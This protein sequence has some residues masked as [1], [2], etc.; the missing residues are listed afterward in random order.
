MGIAKPFKFETIRIISKCS[1][2]KPGSASI[3][4]YLIKM[5]TNLIYNSIV[6]YKSIY[7]KEV[8]VKRQLCMI[9]REDLKLLTEKAAAK[10]FHILCDI[11]S[12]SNIKFNNDKSNS[13]IG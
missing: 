11:A 10:R 1:I 8:T 7:I 2:R 6:V 12:N 4:I 9:R 13:R 5:N 3:A